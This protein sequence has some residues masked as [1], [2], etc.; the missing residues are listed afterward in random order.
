MTGAGDHSLPGIAR[1][2]PITNAIY[3]EHGNEQGEGENQGPNWLNSSRT[4]NRFH[5]LSGCQRK[6][7]RMSLLGLGQKSLLEPY[8]VVL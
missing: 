5:A 2:R 8:T 4:K 1:N 6:A 7:Y 3:Q